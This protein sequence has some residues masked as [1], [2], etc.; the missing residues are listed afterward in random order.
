MTYPYKL[1]AYNSPVYIS[2]KPLRQGPNAVGKEKNQQVCTTSKLV[3]T[4][5]GDGDL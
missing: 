1:T 5:E 2:C 4:R 3:G